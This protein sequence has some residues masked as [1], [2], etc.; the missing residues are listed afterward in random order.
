MGQELDALK[1]EVARDKEVKSS[2]ATLIS[3]IAARIDAARQQ[4]LQEQGVVNRS[5]DDLSKDLA[6]STDALASAVQANTDTSGG[7]GTTDTGGGTT[8]TG[9][10]TTDTGGGTTDTGGGEVVTEG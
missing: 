4:L 1:A 6:S 7:G 2:A 5:L 3:G 10:G 9:G 8:D